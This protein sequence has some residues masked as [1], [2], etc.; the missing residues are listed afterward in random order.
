MKPLAERSLRMPWRLYL[1]LWDV[2]KY[3]MRLLVNLCDRRPLYSWTNLRTLLRMLDSRRLSPSSFP[4]VINNFNRLDSLRI[5]VDWLRSLDGETSIIIL[6]NG[7]SFA[8]L[9]DY[10]RSLRQVPNLQVVR[11]GYNARLYGIEDAVRELRAFRRYV[12][13]DPDLVPYP[14][15]PRDILRHMDALLDRY[16]RFSHVGASLEVRDI[17]DHYPLKAAVQEWESRY[18]PPRATPV[19]ADGY[20]AWVD[21]TFAMYRQGADVTRIEPAMRL[22]RPY[23]LKHVDWY[24]DPAR[25][26]D[27]QRFYQRVSHPVASWTMRL[28]ELRPTADHQHERE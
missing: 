15:T 2:R 20:E 6:D 14:D 28:R 26:T 23:T 10:Y 3:A 17:P 16:P 12:V 5:L 13:T 4:I 18:W 25:L 8:P 1:L 7:S 27:E 9:R 21:T 11:L 22:A 19:G 24:L